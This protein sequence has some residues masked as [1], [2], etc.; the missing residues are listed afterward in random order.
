MIQESSLERASR[1][2]KENPKL[3]DFIFEN[4]EHEAQKDDDMIS[5]YANIH[6][7][8][9]EQAADRIFAIWMNKFSYIDTTEPLHIKTCDDKRG[10]P[11]KSNQAM[12]LIKHLK[13]CRF[14]DKRYMIRDNQ[15][16]QIGTRVYR[17]FISSE[18]FRSKGDPLTANQ[19]DEIVNIHRAHAG[20]AEEKQVYIRSASP[21]GY[22]SYLD[23]NDGKNTIIEIDA[24]GW[25]VSVNAPILF[26]RP[27][28]M[29]SLPI[30]LQYG[31]VEPL[32]EIFNIERSDDF[33][34]IIAALCYILRGRPRDRGSYPIIVA[35]GIEG[36][37][38]TT[39]MKIIKKIIDPGTPETRT[40]SND[41]RDLFIAASNGLVLSLDNISYI[42]REMY[43]ALCSLTTGGGF[44]RKKNYSDDEEQIFDLCRPVLLNGI[45]FDKAPDL[46]SRSIII[47]LSPI[48]QE[49]RKTE[50]EIWSIVEMNKASILGGLLS[51]LSNAI[52][53]DDKMCNERFNLPRL[54]D[55]GRFSVALERGNAWEVGKITSSLKETYHSA[56]HENA[57]GNPIIPIII[58]LIDQNGTWS[59]CSTDLLKA[60]NSKGTEADKKL[61]IWPKTAQKL[62]ILLKKNHNVFYSKG[63]QIKNCRT[64]NERIWELTLLKSK[65]SM[66]DSIPDFEDL[67]FAEKDFVMTQDDN[68]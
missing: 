12:E 35:T 42:N 30:P 34:V 18:F 45:S 57:E 10:R 49:E 6:N 3:L 66:G 19:I 32:K 64:K 59:G 16:I 17:D 51:I 27:V 25:R 46:L 58:N 1:L 5:L 33:S 61:L 63:I 48:P 37:A 56:L 65:S 26:V 2:I 29:E 38:K 43:D 7:L 60:I 53:E 36:S 41:T 24:N 50:S 47:E 13:L 28:N 4:K 55:F 11:R 20:E 15:A 40:P 52:R 68:E 22:I 39:F 9:N 8:T 54:A 31:S 62:G 14:K 67:Q 44:A 21:D 23:L